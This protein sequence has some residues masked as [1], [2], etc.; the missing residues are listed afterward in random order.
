MGL[1][2][3]AFLRQQA[4]GR[5]KLDG[6]F[7]TAARLLAHWDGAFEGGDL[8]AYPQKLSQLEALDEHKLVEAVLSRSAPIE[9]HTE[10]SQPSDNLQ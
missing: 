3:L 9:S 5:T 4:A 7:S 6:L 8:P 1:E 2:K 10:H